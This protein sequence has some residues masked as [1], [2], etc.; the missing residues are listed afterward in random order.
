MPVSQVII[1]CCP[2]VLCSDALCSSSPLPP[3]SASPVP[4]LCRRH[5]CLLSGL[6][7]DHIYPPHGPNVPYPM[8]MLW[9][10]RVAQCAISMRLPS[11][12]SRRSTL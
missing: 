3:L 8:W 11:G 1:D 12:L 6:S 9:P 2:I 4:P 5:M 10:C 7:L